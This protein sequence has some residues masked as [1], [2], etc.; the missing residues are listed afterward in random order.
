MTACVARSPPP[1]KRDRYVADR[2]VKMALRAV[3]LHYSRGA[4]V[5]YLTPLGHEDWMVCGGLRVGRSGSPLLTATFFGESLLQMGPQ[6]W[7]P[8]P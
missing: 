3:C 4:S 6:A 1:S 7:R 2:P 8:M 5:F